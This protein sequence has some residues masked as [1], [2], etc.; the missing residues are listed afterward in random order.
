MVLLSSPSHIYRVELV[1]SETKSEWE[2]DAPLLG[3]DVVV[4]LV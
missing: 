4:I 1:L 3:A 2:K